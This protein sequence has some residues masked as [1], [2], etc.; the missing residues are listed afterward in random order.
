MVFGVISGGLCLTSL[1]MIG[2]CK[3]VF[4]RIRQ[5]FDNL[6]PRF[7][8]IMAPLIGGI[9]VGTMSYVCPLSVGDG[10]M[11]LG[12]IVRFGGL[13]EIS[14][15]VVITSIFAKMFATG[16]SMNCGFVGG[17]VFPMITIGGFAGV[18]AYQQYDYLPYGLCVSCFLAGV[19]A[20]ICPMPF[21][22][23]G[24]PIY[25]MYFGL[26]QTVPI[27]I[28]VITSYTVV[29]GS[30]IFKALVDRGEKN[31]QTAQSVP[32][33][34]SGLNESLL[35]KKEEDYRISQYA[36]NKLQRRPTDF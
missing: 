17:F 18:V 1:V 9:L 7:G 3:Q 16:V 11:V 36:S 32:T 25:V 12:P 26:Y 10:N 23:I 34:E 8:T 29:C 33:D 24:I 21:T 2:I 35:K 5:R 30:G 6:F 13:Q 14:T 22:L 4:A 19:P 28:C 20:G 27:F 15:H 31:N